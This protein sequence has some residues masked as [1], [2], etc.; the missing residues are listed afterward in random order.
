LDNI[1]E[2]LKLEA[3]HKNLEDRFGALPHEALSLLNIVRIRI[4]AQQLGIE[5]LFYKNKQLRINFVNNKNSPF[6]Q[7]AT[8]SNVLQWLQ[9]NQKSAKMEEKNN[10]LWLS[11]P[12]V[13]KMDDILPILTDMLGVQ[14]T[15]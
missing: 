2:V 14:T 3:F 5:K 6:Y 12:K 4:K 15:Q 13:F 11:L 8:F 9:R 7:S 1:K 10:K